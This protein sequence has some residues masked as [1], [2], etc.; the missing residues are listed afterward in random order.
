MLSFKRKLS[1]LLFKIKYLLFYLFK[2]MFLLMNL[3][4]LPVI[5]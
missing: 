2:I 4:G 3:M 1:E 5:R